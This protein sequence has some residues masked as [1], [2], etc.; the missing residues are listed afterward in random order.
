[1][2]K[3]TSCNITEIDEQFPSGSVVIKPLLREHL[4]K[5]SSASH[6]P[7]RLGSTVLEPDSQLVLA[8]GQLGRERL[9][10]SLCEVL[11]RLKLVSQSRQLLLAEGS[12]GFLVPTAAVAG[13]LLCTLACSPG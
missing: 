12:S 13:W 6:I 11:V 4:S 9:A 10:T 8:K 2:Q 5:R 3:D 7:L 1:M